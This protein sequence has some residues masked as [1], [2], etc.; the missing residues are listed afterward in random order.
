[1]S[2]ISPTPTE[3][4]RILGHVGAVQFP[5]WIAAHAAKLG[6]TGGILTQTEQCLEM[7][8]C[9]PPDLLDALAVGCSLG[10]REVWV[11]RIDRALVTGG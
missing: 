9:G 11:D 6:L 8:Y 2:P 5:G 7:R 4:F 3:D 1:M 10:P